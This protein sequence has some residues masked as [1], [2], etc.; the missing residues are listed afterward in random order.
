MYISLQYGY[1]LS[2]S[3]HL[4]L[5]PVSPGAGLP[6]PPKDP[7][8]LEVDPYASEAEIQAIQDGYSVLKSQ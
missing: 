1:F 6:F 2:V 3:I 5:L 7:T 4:F 8:V